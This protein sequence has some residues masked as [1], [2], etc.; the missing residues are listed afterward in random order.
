MYNKYGLKL[1][2]SSGRGYQKGSQKSLKDRITTSMMICVLILVAVTGLRIIGNAASEK[3]LGTIAKLV[4]S[5]TDFE[6]TADNMVNFFTNTV[7][8]LTGKE[9]SVASNEIVTLEPPLI[10]GKLKTGFV[11]SV[12]PVFQTNIAP[13]GIEIASSASALVYAPGKSE[14]DS[15]IVNEDGTKRLTISVSKSTKVV[16]DNLSEAYVDKG[17][18]VSEGMVIGMLPEDNAVLTFK[19]WVDNE[20]KNPIDF[21]GDIY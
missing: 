6:D 3:V 2:N 9:V 18:Q 4:Q 12:H 11:D 5:Q 21:I 15:V 10:E 14:C 16:Y 20:A 8:E 1:R 17:D 13:T 19:I 7:S